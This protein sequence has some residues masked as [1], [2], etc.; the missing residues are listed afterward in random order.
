MKDSTDLL[1]TR[2]GNEQ[3]EIFVVKFFTFCSLVNVCQGRVTEY[4]TLEILIGYEKFAE[5]IGHAMITLNNL[6]KQ[7]QRICGFCK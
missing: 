5:F 3:S 7:L 4:F 6:G 1:K 2:E